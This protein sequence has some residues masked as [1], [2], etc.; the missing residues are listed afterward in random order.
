[1]LYLV[2]YI[3]IHGVEQKAIERPFLSL[4]VSQVKYVCTCLPF[5]LHTIHSHTFWK[6]SLTGTANDGLP[7]CLRQTNLIERSDPSSTRKCFCGRF[8][9]L[10]SHSNIYANDNLLSPAQSKRYDATISSIFLNMNIAYASDHA[11]ELI[12]IIQFYRNRA[13]YHYP[14]SIQ[15]LSS[16]TS[17]VCCLAAPCVGKI[18]HFGCHSFI[19]SV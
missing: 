4:H 13:I 16:N 14:G 7:F 6:H 10:D 5:F 8:D 18:R 11:D 15:L 9:G 1:M 19:H 3:R 17:H 12:L 2:W